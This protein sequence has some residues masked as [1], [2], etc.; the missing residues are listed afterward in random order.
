MQ[1][2][3]ALFLLL[4]AIGQPVRA[5]F[6]VDFV[7]QT[8]ES[9][10]FE[11]LETEFSAAHQSALDQRD[12]S[13]LRSVYSVLFVTANRDR[14]ELSKAWLEAYPAS[15]YAAT[16]LA[17]SHYYRAFLVRGPAAYGSTSPR[18]IDGFEDEMQSASHYAAL[19][20][21]SA[22]D[23]LPALDAAILL[24]EVRGDY[25]G[26]LTIVDRELDIAPDRHAILLGLAAA[27]LNWGGSAAEIIAL[28]GAMTERIPDYDAELCFI[29]AV[30]ENGLGGR[31]RQAALEALDRRDEGFLDYARLAAYLGEWSDRPEAP[32]EVVRLH[33]A[34]LGPEMIVPVYVDQLAR[35]NRTFQMPFY[36]IEAHDAMIAVLTDRLPD[37][38]QSHRILRVLIEDSLDRYLRRDPTASIAQAQDHWYEMLAHGAYLPETWALGRRLDAVANG[39]WQ[40]ERQMPYFQNQ[41][42]YGNHDVSY[43][44]S[45]LIYLFE[46]QSIATGE[47]RLAPN[48]TLDPEAIGEA[49]RCEL[50]RAT[51][52]YDYLCTAA[53]NQ[54]FCSIG[55]WA[56]DF[57]DRARRMME[58]SS[59]C[60]WVKAAP[61]HQLGFSPVPTDYFTA[62]AR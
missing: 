61:V 62:T 22:D 26:M 48:S 56:S 36:E 14:M 28:C 27:N 30:F 20:V 15:P 49:T 33:R 4:M 23:F 46:A 3:I 1:R 50:F 60:A 43:V 51:R 53:P 44:R 10:D 54:N 37:N 21:E 19:A 13:Q 39:T 18:A 29:D 38:P 32:D 6:G 47:A 2:L 25:G 55:G 52:I 17:W 24:R 11:Q 8:L 34:S 5:E 7:R 35:I 9:R 16:A 40:V 45:Y 41:I 12:F 57:P 31:W 59:D 58:N 42:F